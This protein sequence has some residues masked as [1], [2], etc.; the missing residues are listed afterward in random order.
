MPVSKKDIDASIQSPPDDEPDPDDV[1][2]FVNKGDVS[3]EEPSSGDEE[4]SSSERETQRIAIYFSEETAKKLRMYCAEQE[5]PMS[6]VV[7]EIV[8]GELE[9]WMPEF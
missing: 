3:E 8:A 4:S 6:R 2:Q 7:D 1:D 9:D 5:R